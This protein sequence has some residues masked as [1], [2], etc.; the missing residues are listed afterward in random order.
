M[1][2]AALG[3]TS[4]RFV[5]G[6]VKAGDYRFAVGIGRQ[7][8]PRSS[9]PSSL[10]DAGR[11]RAG[12][13]IEGGTH[14]HAAPPFP[15]LERTFL[16]LSERMGVRVQI[17]LE[18]PGFY[19]AGGGRFTAE[20]Q[21]AARLKPLHLGERAELTGRRV[22]AIVANLPRDIA[23]REVKTAARLLEWG[24]GDPGG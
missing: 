7:R 6:A 22:V 9:R 20:I 10:P 16:P 4:I 23:E 12:W 17:R 2:G 13:S 14:N 11:G 18:R 5:P 1:E 24:T 21:P 19:P 8:D 3:S 15:F